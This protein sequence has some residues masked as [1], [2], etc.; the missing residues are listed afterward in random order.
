MQLHKAVLLLI[1]GGVNINALTRG[2][3]NII[4]NFVGRDIEGLK[5]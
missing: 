4:V 3:A 5:K 2:E 1:L